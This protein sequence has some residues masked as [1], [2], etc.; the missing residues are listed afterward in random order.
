MKISV[1]TYNSFA[2]LL[3]I[4]NTKTFIISV[5]GNCFATFCKFVFNG[6]WRKI[7]LFFKKQS[8]TPSNFCKL[9]KLYQRHKQ[10]NLVC[11]MDMLVHDLK[12][13]QLCSF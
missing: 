13:E 9:L 7:W 3:Y 8:A 4:Q 1:L 10:Y 6:K 12:I 2:K 11:N 5:A